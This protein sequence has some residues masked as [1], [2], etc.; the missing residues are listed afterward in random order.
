MGKAI[1]VIM[2]LIYHFTRFETFM[3][4]I[5]PSQ[6]LRTSSLRH[7]NDPRESLDWTFG[8]TNLPYEEIFQGYYSA[9]THI[10]CQIKYGN[11]IKDSYQVLCFSGAEGEGWNNEMMWTHY[12]GLHSGVC[13]EFDENILLNNLQNLYPDLTYHLENIDYSNRKTDPWIYWEKN[14]NET[15]N[16]KDI[17]QY[18]VKDMTLSKSMFWKG[19]DERRLVCRG[20]DKSLYIPISNALKTVYLGVTFQLSKV[21]IDSIFE[22]FNNRFNLSLLIYQNNSFERWGIKRLSNGKFGTCD[23]EDLNT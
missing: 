10:D 5:L 6:R 12:G 15:E 14:K 21:L 3:S 22:M 11:M 17:L 20:V 19:E 7:M 16:M 2:S 1:N 8:S 4:Y 18:L 23:F 9:K 13:L